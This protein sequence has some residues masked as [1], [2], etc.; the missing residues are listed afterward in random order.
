MSEIRMIRSLFKR[1]FQPW[2]ELRVLF[3]AQRPPELEEGAGVAVRARGLADLPE[4][5]AA[6][7]VTVEVQ[8][9]GLEQGPVALFPERQQLRGVLRP[10]LLMNSSSSP[11]FDDLMNLFIK[12]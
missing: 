1:I 11:N 5:Q 3:G 7:A 2:Y 12:N 8:L 6:V 9:P 4:V 10:K